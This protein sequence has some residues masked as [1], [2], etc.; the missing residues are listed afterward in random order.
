MMDADRLLAERL[1]AR[2]REEFSKVSDVEVADG[3]SIREIG[4]RVSA[5]EGLVQ[6]MASYMVQAIG[7]G[8]TGRCATERCA[9]SAAV[10]YVF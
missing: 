8:I 1:Q 7:A 9:D 4:P 3:I 2:E 5:V 10:D 6:V